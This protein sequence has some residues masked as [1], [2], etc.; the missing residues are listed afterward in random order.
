LKYLHE[1]GCP[2]N[3]KCCQN[4]SMNGYLEV[5]IYLHENGCPWNKK[6]CEYASGLL[7]DGNLECLKYLHEN[8]F[9]LKNVVKLHQGMDN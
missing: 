3:E 7:H 5:L 6:C 2:W 1:N 9:P 4:A 8:G